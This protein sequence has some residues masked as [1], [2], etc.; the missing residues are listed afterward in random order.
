MPQRFSSDPNYQRRQAQYMAQ[1]LTAFAD[2]K[3]QKREKIDERWQRTQAMIVKSVEN[4]ADPAQFEH[5]LK[6]REAVGDETVGVFRELLKS[7][8]GKKTAVRKALEPFFPPKVEAT[9]GTAMMPSMGRGAAPMIGPEFTATQDPRL[10]AYLAA[11]DD[12]PLNMM[13]VSRFPAPQQ[14]LYH[15]GQLPPESQEAARIGAGLETGAGE[16]LRAELE[17]GRQAAK[18]VDQDLTRQQEERLSKQGGA[19][20][21][22]KKEGKLTTSQ[23]LADLK[24]DLKAEMGERYKKIPQSQLRRIAAFY[25]TAADTLPPEALAGY[26]AWAAA[27]LKKGIP[28]E[29]VLEG[30]KGSAKRD[31]G[32]K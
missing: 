31:Y 29:R 22:A 17:R 2:R 23:E 13:D 5:Y 18:A 11:P 30:L 8:A 28:P 9:G 12:V 7:T 27:E 16:N 1:V 20:P 24:V 15:S 26:R 10:A 32:I 3:E 25:A 14:A 21:P 6:D 4:G 19:T